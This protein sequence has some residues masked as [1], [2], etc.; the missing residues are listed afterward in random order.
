M[1]PRIVESTEPYPGRWTH[2]VIIQNAD[3]V[4]EQVKEW[5]REAYHFANTK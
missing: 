1:A 5:I 2:H 3:E 4:D